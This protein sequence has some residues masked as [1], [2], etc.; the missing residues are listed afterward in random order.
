MTFLNDQMA[1][2]TPAAT[3]YPRSFLWVPFAIVVRASLPQRDDPGMRFQLVVFGIHRRLG[4][5][6]LLYMVINRSVQQRTNQLTPTL[7]A[8]VDRLEILVLEDHARM[9]ELLNSNRVVE[10]ERAGIAR[11]RGDIEE[12]RGEFA[13]SRQLSEVSEIVEGR[14]VAAG[15]ESVSMSLVT[16]SR[17]RPSTRLCVQSIGST[18]RMPMANARCESTRSVFPPSSRC[19]M[20]PTPPASATPPSC[21]FC[22]GGMGGRL[23]GL[24][25]WIDA[26]CCEIVALHHRGTETQRCAADVN[27]LV[28]F[29][30]SIVGPLTVN[31][32][33]KERQDR[34]DHCGLSVSIDRNGS[35]GR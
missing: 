27:V 19:P 34:Q 10:D 8:E 13:A 26:G 5:V 11:L 3:I 21:G 23:W 2:G 32:Y 15:I 35:A 18:Y 14:L 20:L 22:V 4:A 9:V 29:G 16:S 31:F 1:G 25:R 12:I 24:R 17:V 33:R 28:A 7:R 30:S 6:V